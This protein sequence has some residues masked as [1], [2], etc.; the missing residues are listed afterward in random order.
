MNLKIA[1]FSAFFSFLTPP[2]VESYVV[3]S[4]PAVQLFAQQDL[5]EPPSCQEQLEQVLSYVDTSLQS[6]VLFVMELDTYLRNMGLTQG[7][8]F[9]SYQEISPKEADLTVIAKSAAKDAGEAKEKPQ[10]PEAPKPLFFFG[11]EKEMREKAKLYPAENYETYLRMVN[12]PTSPLTPDFLKQSYSSLAETLIHERMHDEIDLPLEIEEALCDAAAYRLAHDFLKPGLHSSE[13]V[14]E[15]EAHAEKQEQKARSLVQAEADLQKIEERK[16]ISGE[17]K[18]KLRQR[19][20]SSLQKELDVPTYTQAM[21]IRE[22]YYH[23]YFRELYRFPK[24]M[25]LS[26][27]ETLSWYL[28]LSS[29]KEK[30]EKEIREWC[31][32]LKCLN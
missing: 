29:E 14:K 24:Q 20:F 11:T 10:A 12:T 2:S 4:L 31:A 26:I 32:T 22:M 23:R 25:D 7:R 18:E 15:I 30:A 1:L 16:D 17:E 28:S 27:E 13:A 6:K 8:A 5:S 21:L 3:P 9:C 19:R